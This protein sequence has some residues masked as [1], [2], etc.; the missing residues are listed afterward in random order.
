[1]VSSIMQPQTASVSSSDGGCCSAYKHM[2]AGA[3]NQ[4]GIR[5]SGS[6]ETLCI[7]PGQPSKVKTLRKSSLIRRLILLEQFS[8][9][10]SM[11]ASQR[12]VA[13]NRCVFFV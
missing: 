6:Q 9:S 10:G 3:L 2:N 1:M 5:E 7:P 8:S 11:K 4:I 12:E 13:E